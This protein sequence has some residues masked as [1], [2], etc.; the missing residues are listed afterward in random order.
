MTNSHQIWL[1]DLIHSCS[2]NRWSVAS[3]AMQ[4]KTAHDRHD[5]SDRAA[6]CS[7]E[8]CQWVA[9]SSSCDIRVCQHHIA[10]HLLVPFKV[11]FRNAGTMRYCW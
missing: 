1:R 11:R 9:R 3:C 6:F 7:P 8:V 2:T 4:V 10:G 5:E